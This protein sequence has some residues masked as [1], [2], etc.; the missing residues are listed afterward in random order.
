MFSTSHPDTLQHIT[1]RHPLRRRYHDRPVYLRQLNQRKLGI[2]GARRHVDEQVVQLAPID[3]LQELAD[4]PHHDRP[5][6]DRRR[7]FV[8][9]EPDAHQLDTMSFQRDDALVRSHARPGVDAEHNRDVRAVY[10]GIHEPDLEAQLG[11]RCRQIGSDGGFPYPAF[12]GAHRNDMAHS[13]HRLRFWHTPLRWRLLDSLVAAARTHDRQLAP[14][15]HPISILRPI[16]RHLSVTSVVRFERTPTPSPARSGEPNKNG[17]GAPVPVWNSTPSR[18][19]TATTDLTSGSRLFN[20]CS[21]PP[22]N[23]RSE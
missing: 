3:L 1:D 6:P 15:L 23:V 18:C 17:T 2:T 5:A 20:R 14:T 11:E 7:I 12:A 10:I 8:D 4:D 22:F 21:M 19:Q 13:G 9:K 16:L